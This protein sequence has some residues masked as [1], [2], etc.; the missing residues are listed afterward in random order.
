MIQPGQ[1]RMLKPMVLSAAAALGGCSSTTEVEHPQLEVA[2]AAYQ[3]AERDPEVAQN[4]PDELRKARQALAV[5]EQL[6]RSGAEA[7]ELDHYVYLARQRIAIA[8]QMAELESVHRAL[9]RAA[10]Q[11]D[12]LAPVVRARKA[13]SGATNTEK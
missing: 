4:A 7:E 2:R 13:Q 11:R 10:A 3:T 5:A 12:K 6:W 9:E 8:H 1:W